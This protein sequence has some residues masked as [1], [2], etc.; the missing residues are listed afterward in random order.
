[1]KTIAIVVGHG[2]NID[3]GA[4][5]GSVTELD[6]NRDLAKQII[7][8]IGN[9]AK[10]VLVNRVIE[11][12]QP[13]KQT[14]DTKADAAV[15]LHLNAFNKKATGTEMIHSGSEKGIALAKALQTAAVKVLG[16]TDRGIK[17]PQGGGRGA[18]WLNRTNM[19]AVI[20]ESFFIDNDSDL[21]KGNSVK[22]ALAKAYADALVN[23]VS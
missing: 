14:N 8:A 11:R 10:A 7:S 6:W 2:P 16:L 23:F 21:A 15:E 19:P 1:M 13:V 18:G 22:P 12:A 3:R 17:L 9:R 5:N 4:T 20:V